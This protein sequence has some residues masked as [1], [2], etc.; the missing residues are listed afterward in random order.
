M[1]KNLWSFVNFLQILKYFRTRLTF[2]AEFTVFAME[3][4][5]RSSECG[6]RAKSVTK[7]RFN[8]IRTTLFIELCW[9]LKTCNG[10]KHFT[11]EVLKYNGLLRNNFKITHRLLLEIRQL[12]NK[13]KTSCTLSNTQSQ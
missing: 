11:L 8:S 7:P 2:S 10:E 3:G 12:R 6:I 9:P 13:I 5:E 1:Q 4:L